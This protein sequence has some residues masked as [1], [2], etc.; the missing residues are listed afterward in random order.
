MS[1]LS[2]NELNLL[3]KEK[4]TTLKNVNAT[5]NA[6]NSSY[7]GKDK[8]KSLALSKAGLKES[9]VYNLTVE[10]DADDGILVYEVDFKT[11]EKEY[12]YEINAK[13]G[14]FIDSEVDYNDDYY[15]DKKS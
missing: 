6:S 13:T 14:T 5:G 7:I 2:I 11:K 4:E 1:K 3:L 15:E 10:L 8:A 9:E 12:E